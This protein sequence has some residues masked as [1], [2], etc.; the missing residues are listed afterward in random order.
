[1][2][3]VIHLLAALSGLLLGLVYVYKTR[4]RRAGRASQKRGA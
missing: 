1:M 4:D 3:V 2:P